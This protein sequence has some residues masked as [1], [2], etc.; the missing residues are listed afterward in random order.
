MTMT[1]EIATLT[2]MAATMMTMKT[3]RQSGDNDHEEEEEENDDDDD[4]I[5]H[6]RNDDADNENDGDPT[7]A[8]TRM[9]GRVTA[10]SARA[11][12]LKPED[13]DRHTLRRR[14][15]LVHLL[16]SGRGCG[17]FWSGISFPM[18]S[19]L[20]TKCSKWERTLELRC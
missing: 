16:Y 15:T 2:F 1:L 10:Y 11:N 4:D 5:D 6:L 13:R 19:L 8:R 18:V 12:G 9:P 17:F 3:P 20:L 7:L 14:C